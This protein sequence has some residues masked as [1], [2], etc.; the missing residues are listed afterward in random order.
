[1][2]PGADP[3]PAAPVTDAAPDDLTSRA[4]TWIPILL[5]HARLYSED[6]AAAAAALDDQ[7]PLAQAC[8]SDLVLAFLIAL[9]LIAGAG[10]LETEDLE[11]ILRTLTASLST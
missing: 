3:Y 8:P 4:A 7:N 2:D 5:F 6:P 1:M 10:G 11:E 9:D